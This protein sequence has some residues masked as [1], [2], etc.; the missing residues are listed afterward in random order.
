MKKILKIFP[1]IILLL[2]SVLIVS[3]KDMEEKELYKSILG[4]QST[5]FIIPEN[6][7]QI[8][9]NKIEE[10]Y[11]AAKEHNVL[12]A[13]TIYNEENNSIDTFIT[14]NNIYNLLSNQLDMKEDLSSNHQNILTTFDSN[15]NGYY[16]PD[17]LNNDRYSFF[18]IEKTKEQN[19]YKYG[20]YTLY[21]QSEQNRHDFF[22]EA[23]NILDVPIESLT[24]E[25]WGQLNEPI[26]TFEISILIGLAFFI[27]LYF[28]LVLFLMYRESKK[29]GVLSLL[30]FSNRE[31]I[32][33]MMKQHI[34]IILIGSISIITIFALLLPNIKSNVILSLLFVHFLVVV[35]SLCLSFIALVFLQKYLKLSNILKK[36]SIVKKISNL[37]LF[38][39]FIMIGSMLLLAVYFIPLMN[40]NVKMTNS[41]KDNEVLM[42]YAVF[43]RIR[44]EN[45]E[46]EDYSRYLHFYRAL[47]ESDI[48][49]I[50]VNYEGYLETDED[51]VKNYERMEPNGQAYRIASVDINYL[52]LY[53][54]YCYTSD[55]ETV[56][57]N[58]INQEFYLLPDSKK[59]YTQKFKERT[60]EKYDKYGI[61]QSVLV[62]YYKDQKFDTFDSQKGIKQ[63]SSPIFR[64]VH[65]S[66]PYTYFEKSY[67][68]DVA[69][70]GMDTAL[71]FK[72][73]ETE[74]YYKTVL[75]EPIKQSGLEEVLVEENLVKYKDYYGDLIL[76]TRR[77]NALFIASMSVCIIIYIM[78]LVQ[79][80]ILFVEARKD[81]ILVKTLIGYSRKDI[82]ESVIYWNIGATILPISCVLAYSIASNAPNLF[83]L[84][85]L[86]FIFFILD[87]LILVIITKTLNLKNIYVKLKGE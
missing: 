19:I 72:V 73:S 64:V 69:A 63:V 30:G 83:I 59:E 87:I 31:I 17:F 62:F 42:D 55:G 43:P 53:S 16:Y 36:Q 13:K 51:T 68:L 74:N 78:M 14:T 58:N 79:T 52:N 3:L 23:K 38:T 71:K 37:C 66:N 26:E 22:Q 7:E 48:D 34:I 47:A 20:S 50:Y 24:S 2:L 29:I 27:L 10:I 9:D 40:E 6:N 39:K 81:E 46:Y 21:Y 45:G 76:K 49:Y 15:Y 33:Q 61:S 41:L 18:S 1:I 28:I 25:Y 80:F 44:V 56:D 12:L 32:K 75:L 82:F 57:I 54:P 35:M 4:Y 11:Q 77:T 65:E 85:F 8:N 67:G 60:Q 70:T 84:L 5:S 86:S